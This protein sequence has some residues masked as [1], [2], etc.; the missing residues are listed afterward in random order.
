VFRSRRVLYY[1]TKAKFPY[2]AGTAEP[3]T[4]FIPQSTESGEYEA[5]LNVIADFA[6]VGPMLHI[7][8]DLLAH[9]YDP[10]RDVLPL[11]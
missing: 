4:P 10:G 5:G 2:P 11:L 6:T 9:I 3:A 7:S 1:D 8:L